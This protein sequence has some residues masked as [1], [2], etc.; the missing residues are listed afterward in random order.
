MVDDRLDPQARDILLMAT[1]PTRCE[2][3]ARI[4]A[5]N[6]QSRSPRSSSVIKLSP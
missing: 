5:V 3:R 4:D 6:R 2:H 1:N